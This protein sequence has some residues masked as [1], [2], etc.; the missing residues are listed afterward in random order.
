MATSEDTSP[1]DSSS[2]QTPPPQTSSS[3]KTPTAV[4]AAG[5]P[6]RPSALQDWT[7]V[8]LSVSRAA[9][10]GDMRAVVDGNGDDDEDDEDDYSDEEEETAVD[11]EEDL[12]DDDALEEKR[13]SGG[14]VRRR[15]SDD[16]RRLL[17][18]DEKKKKQQQ[19][20]PRRFANLEAVLR[21]GFHPNVRPL[22]IADLES[23][24][25]LEEAAFMDPEHRCTREKFEYRLSTCP[26][27]CLGLFC[28][29]VPSEIQDT[30]IELVTLPTSHPVETGR[31]NGA[32]SVL[33]AHVVS[34]RSH[35][36][37]VTDAAMD[38]P[39]DFRIRKGVDDAE[40]GHQAAGQTVCMH[41][42]AVHPKMQGFGLGKLI[43]KAY[44]QQQK[45]SGAA[46]R[47]A[48]ICQDH[49]VR[50]YERFLFEYGGPSKATFGGGGWHDMVLDVDD[51]PPRANKRS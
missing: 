32:K 43:V 45:G 49:L 27:L 31:A 47:C 28:T 23:C 38:Y 48:L 14:Y 18:D 6:R 50:Y 51:I 16:L 30:D 13:R 8:L 2:P 26:E 1:P 10:N 19:P 34:T 35:D 5:P 4:T 25:A 46:R 40:R 39:H 9:N 12:L 15:L 11:D 42:V 3:P 37:M 21:F 33:L 17:G 7:R 22:S 36:P 41:S 24:V 44:L 29:V 20:P